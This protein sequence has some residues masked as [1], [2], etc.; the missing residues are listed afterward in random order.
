MNTFLLFLAY[1]AFLGCYCRRQITQIGNLSSWTPCSSQCWC[2]Q[3]DKGRDYGRCIV[4]KFEESVELNFSRKLHFLSFA[5]NGLRAVLRGIFTNLHNLEF[6]SLAN[7]SIEIINEHAFEGLSNLRILD[8]QNNNLKKWAG[9]PTRDMPL[10]E[11]LNLNGN[12]GWIPNQ[13]ILRMP[14]LK[15]I[16]GITWSSHCSTCDLL[17][18]TENETLVDDDEMEDYEENSGDGLSGKGEM[19][20]MKCHVTLEE[21]YYPKAVNYG[22]SAQFVRQGFSP[23][24]FC[25]Y[26]SDCYNRE[27][28]VPYLTQL[29]DFPRKLFLSQ[30]AL[31]GLI[32]ILTMSVLV[33]I[34]T[35]RLLRNNISFVLVGSMALSD[36]LIGVHSVAIAKYNIFSDP[37]VKPRVVMERDTSVCTYIGMVFT[38]GQVTAVFTSLMLTVERY[39]VIVYY[40]KCRGKV[41]IRPLVIILFLVWTGAITF[42]SLPLF[43]VGKLKYHRWFQCTMPYHSGKNLLQTSNITLSI[44]AIFVFLYLI[45]LGLYIL[46]F[47]YARRS[48]LQFGIKR[49]ARLARKI[50]MLVSSNFI[51][52]TLPTVLLLVYVYSFSEI[53]DAA[54]SFSSMRSLFIIGGWLPV[55]CFN[56]NSLANPFLYPFRHCRFKKELRS[57]PRRLRNGVSHTFYPVF[58]TA[59]HFSLRTSAISHQLRQQFHSFTSRRE[60]ENSLHVD[61]DTR[62]GR[63]QTATV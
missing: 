43:G 16:L 32:V 27:V 44:S 47:C 5:N 61:L 22:V 18:I 11:I 28:F 56:L 25:D 39:L 46:I 59:Q 53:L 49:E 62:K 8:L 40:H 45:S 21:F 55:T 23:Q 48:S 6:L 63:G 33:V 9:D 36:V 57:I 41:R 54:K 34:I 29:Y 17:K 58:A 42:A 1:F 14:K 26:L 13:Q 50:A 15:E 51:L 52:F 3:D 38:I 30:Y 37:N 10:L 2:A 60:G 24:C 4:N 35:S 12:E 20:E 19:S 31:G 7:N